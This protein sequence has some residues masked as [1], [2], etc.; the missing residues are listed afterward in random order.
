MKY[1]KKIQL[2]TK[3]TTL[4]VANYGKCVKLSTDPCGTSSCW[5][6]SLEKL[7]PILVLKTLLFFMYAAIWRR[8][9]ATWKVWTIEH[10]H[11]MSF[12]ADTP[13]P[14]RRRR[15]LY[16]LSMKSVGESIWENQLL[17]AFFWSQ[18]GIWKIHSWWPTLH[19]PIFHGV[20]LHCKSEE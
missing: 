5:L 12:A 6:R 3:H 19:L 2:H 7:S 14:C 13:S 10:L 8:I 11:A 15:R 16:V 17:N 18:I 9:L 1:T 20:F 4:F